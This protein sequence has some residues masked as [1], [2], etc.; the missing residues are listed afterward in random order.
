MGE[1]KKRGWVSEIHEQVS[2]LREDIAVVLA[3]VDYLTDDVREIK[4]QV[5]EHTKKLDLNTIIL[6]GYGTVGAMSMMISAAN[7]I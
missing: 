3:K 6:V 5:E 7:L 2:K 1:V 4:D